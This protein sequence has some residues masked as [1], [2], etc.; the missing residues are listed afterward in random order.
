MNFC[1]FWEENYRE[2]EG[3]LIN[4]DNPVCDYVSDEYF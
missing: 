1:E 3:V 2:K 4:Y